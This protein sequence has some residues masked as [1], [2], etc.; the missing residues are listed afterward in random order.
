[1]T[2]GTTR[3]AIWAAV[4]A[5]PLVAFA[6]SWQATYAEAQR[7]EEWLIPVKGYDPSDLLRGHFI[8]YQYDWPGDAQPRQPFE[9][10]WAATA[11]AL[12]LHG[13]APDLVSVTNDFADPSDRAKAGCDAIVRASSG[14]RAEARG[15]ATGI[16]YVSEL[17]ARTLQDKLRDP[18]FQGL[19]RVRINDAG[20]M[21]PLDMTFRPRAP[22]G[23]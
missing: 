1:M 9:L 13:K 8:Q 14:T 2:G 4:L 18:K 20:A 6:Y 12:C 16:L 22:S 23:Q 21:R 7:G 5:L 11:N 19:V 17:R 3:R 10:G 15:L